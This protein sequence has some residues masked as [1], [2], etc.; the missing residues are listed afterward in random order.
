M[1]ASISL[2]IIL[3]PLSFSLYADQ[4]HKCTDKSGEVIY[5]DVNCGSQ[6]KV[7][8]VTLSQPPS[9]GVEIRLTEKEHAFLQTR[10][11]K[12][13]QRQKHLGKKRE[14]N[15]RKLAAKKAD[16][17][18]ARDNLGRLKKVNISTQRRWKLRMEIHKRC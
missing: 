6:N 15:R 1:K 11:V 16:C 7:D 8:E 5:S 10:K 12:N 3:L 9:L 17:Q 18:R 2:C 13:N 14:A 4:I